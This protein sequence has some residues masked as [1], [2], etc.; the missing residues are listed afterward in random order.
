[1]E[2]NES[3][4]LQVQSLQEWRNQVTVTSGD[5]SGVTSSSVPVCE[6]AETSSM[7]TTRQLIELLEKAGYFDALVSLSLL[8]H[9][10][11]LQCLCSCHV[12]SVL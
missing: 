5:E 9:Y 7:E 12:I 2:L 10:I 6:S 3:E 1:M 8:I 4:F 11:G